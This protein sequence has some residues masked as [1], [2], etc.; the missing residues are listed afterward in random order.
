MLQLLIVLAI[1]A[2]HMRWGVDLLGWVAVVPALR[3]ARTRHGW[4]S[5][6]VLTITL[7]VAWTVATLKI[8]TAPLSP[9]FALPVGLTLGLAQAVGYLGWG[10]LHWRVSATVA[11]LAFAAAMTTIEWTLYTWSPL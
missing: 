10:W 11:S 3:Y 7:I 6:A 9:A 5:A 4:K 1:A 2:A 8:T